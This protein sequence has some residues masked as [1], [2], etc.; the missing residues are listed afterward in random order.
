V[1][2]RIIGDFTRRGSAVV[3]R[4]AHLPGGVECIGGQEASPIPSS[5]AYLLTILGSLLLTR[6]AMAEAAQGQS[7]TSK[8]LKTRGSIPALL[9]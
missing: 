3:D 7:D 6:L 1:L 4:G 5:V 8:K 9:C 2:Q